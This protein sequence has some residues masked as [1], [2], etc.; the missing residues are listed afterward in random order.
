MI[1]RKGTLADL[2]SIVRIYKATLN[3]M[4]NPHKMFKIYINKGYCFIIEDTEVRG[5]MTFDISRM[6]NP[7]EKGHGREKYLWLEQLV[8]EP[9]YQGQ[10]LGGRLVKYT[11]NQF[12]L[13]TRLCCNTDM[14][15]WYKRFGFIVYQIVSINKR[16]QSIMILGR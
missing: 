5:T 6:F 1:I 11:I 7:Y 2:E 4:V 9:T 13:E 8:I 12:T 15:E 14:V 10:G 16:N 3:N